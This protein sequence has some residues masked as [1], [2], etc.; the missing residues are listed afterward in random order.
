MKIS[1]QTLIPFLLVDAIALY[2]FLT[3]IEA[4]IF[5][6]TALILVGSLWWLKK[7]IQGQKTEMEEK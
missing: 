1:K 2:F 7:V 3:T 4:W 6:L 5:W